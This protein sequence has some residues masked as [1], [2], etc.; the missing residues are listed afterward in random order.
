MPSTPRTYTIQLGA[1]TLEPGFPDANTVNIAS[2]PGGYTTIVRDIVLSVNQWN[3]GDAITVELQSSSTGAAPS[4]I[5]GIN[6][7]DLPGGP[8]L[9]H[10]EGRLRMRAGDELVLLYLSGGS[11]GPI[12]SVVVTGYQFLGA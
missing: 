7:S 11:F 1:A 6:D 9:F 8:Q 12:A 4:L 10:W 5:F 2:N 3:I